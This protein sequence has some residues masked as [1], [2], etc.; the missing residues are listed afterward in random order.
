MKAAKKKQAVAK[1]MCEKNM[2]DIQAGMRFRR[3]FRFFATRLWQWQISP[4]RLWAVS[5]QRLSPARTNVPCVGPTS[6]RR[7]WL[8]NLHAHR[9]LIKAEF[10]PLL[11]HGSSGEFAQS[12]ATQSSNIDI[13]K[14]RKSP[15]TSHWLI[16]THRTEFI[17]LRASSCSR[18][19]NQLI[20][21]LVSHHQ[22]KKKGT[23]ATRQI[24]T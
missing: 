8:S 5:W 13:I 3:N 19:V 24:L 4:S 14:L 11:L 6:T 16:A 22:P 15:P 21:C 7:V 20:N 12:N 9:S 1:H 10:M 17:H 23:R 2:A 18:G